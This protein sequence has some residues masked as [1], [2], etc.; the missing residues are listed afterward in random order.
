MKAIGLFALERVGIGV[1][2]DLPRRERFAPRLRFPMHSRFHFE[3]G[4]RRR[5]QSLPAPHHSMLFAVAQFTWTR[6]FPA[7][8][9]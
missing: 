3:Q 4:I 6:N 5:G 9:A 1:P 7:M 8:P 2:A